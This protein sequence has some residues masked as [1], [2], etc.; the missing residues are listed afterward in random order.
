[1]LFGIRSRI[2]LY[3][4][5]HHR[6]NLRV[7]KRDMPLFCEKIGFINP[8]KQ[9]KAAQICNSGRWERVS[10]QYGMAMLVESVEITDQWVDMYDVVNSD[11]G[12]F[13]ANGMIVHNCN[14]DMTKIALIYLR[15]A[16]RGYDA[17]TVNTVH[18]E[19]VVE[20]RDDQAEEVKQIVEDAM[21][22]AGE[23]ILKVVP[24]VAEASVADYWSK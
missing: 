16:L 23:V 8:A 13:M 10:P 14:A 18:D 12:R 1:M 22:R 11:T 3:T 7:L 24:I 15:T 20:V 6:I 4:N 5:R 19:I 2:N 17:R 21:V 9:E